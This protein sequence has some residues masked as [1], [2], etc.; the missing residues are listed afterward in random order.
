MLGGGNTTG[1]M[2]GPTLFSLIIVTL[3]D[4]SVIFWVG[5]Q[6]WRTFVSQSSDGG[7]AE[8]YAIDQSADRRFELFF[9]IPILL[10]DLHRKSRCA[11]RTGTI[12]YWRELYTGI[13]A[14]WQ[15]DGQWPLWS[16]LDHAR[17]HRSA[18]SC[19]C[20]IPLLV[21]AASPAL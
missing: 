15:T 12:S 4:L 10:V 7:S 8:Q 5:A 21:S 1:Q 3:V 9:S 19:A 2:D 16:I 13:S 17:D 20:Y 18:G 6:L 11:Y 14:L